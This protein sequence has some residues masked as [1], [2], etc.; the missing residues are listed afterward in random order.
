MVKEVVVWGGRELI[1]RDENLVCISFIKKGMYW[2][3]W[4]GRRFLRTLGYFKVVFNRG[5]S[6]FFRGYLVMFRDDVGCYILVRGVGWFE[7]GLGE[8]VIVV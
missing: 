3:M 8:V 6:I 5:D 2:F 1:A 4:L 7:G